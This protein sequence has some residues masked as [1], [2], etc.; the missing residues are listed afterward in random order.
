MIVF[1]KV[2]NI[3]ERGRKR[4]EVFCYKLCNIYKS[5]RINIKSKMCNIE[6]RDRK[7]RQPVVNCVTF[8]KEVEKIDGI[9]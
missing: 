2:H 3:Q 8:K 4:S 5:G 7:K 6:E 9:S 1:C